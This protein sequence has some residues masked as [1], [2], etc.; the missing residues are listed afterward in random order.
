MDD[1]ALMLAGELAERA[2]GHGRP[3][4]KDEILS[5]YMRIPADARADFLDFLEGGLLIGGAIRLAAGRQALSEAQSMMWGTIDYLRER[6][7]HKFG[8]SHGPED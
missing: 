8:D 5:A 1:D 2:D 6:S 4:T 3:P 7:G